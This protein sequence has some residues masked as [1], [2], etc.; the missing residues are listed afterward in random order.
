MVDSVLH[1]A[2]G[3]ERIDALKGGDDETTREMIRKGLSREKNYKSGVSSLKEALKLLKE[4]KKRSIEWKAKHQAIVIQRFRERVLAFEKNPELFKDDEIRSL[5][6]QTRS[7]E[8]RKFL[9]DNP[10]WVDRLQRKIEEAR[11]QK[12]VAAEKSRIKAEEK[13]K[14]RSPALRLPHSPK[15]EEKDKQ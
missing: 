3:P 12:R 9:K 13:W 11:K 1:K 6:Y 5:T 7:S 8:L 15:I 4:S 14:W 2:A 10:S